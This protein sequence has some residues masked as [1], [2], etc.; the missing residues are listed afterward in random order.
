MSHRTLGDKNVESS[1]EDGRPG[2]EASDKFKYCQGYLGFKIK[3]VTLVS[4]GPVTINKIPALL[5]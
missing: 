3:S 2:L 1:T 5:K 4:W